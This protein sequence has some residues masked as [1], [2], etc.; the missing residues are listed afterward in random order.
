MSKFQILEKHYPKLLVLINCLKY[1]VKG[2]TLLGEGDKGDLI[3]IC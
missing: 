1:M 3:L 2:E